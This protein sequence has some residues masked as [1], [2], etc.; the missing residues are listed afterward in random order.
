MSAGELELYSTQDLVDEL[1]RR[2][3]FQGVIVHAK[4]GAKSPT[5]EGERV[6]SVRHS[7]SLGTEEAGRLLDAVGQYIAGMA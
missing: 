3:T 6:F 7:P 2:T 5:W 4:D 1:L